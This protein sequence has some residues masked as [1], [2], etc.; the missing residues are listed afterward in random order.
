MPG[1]GSGPR[2]GALGQAA[3]LGEKV[4]ISPSACFILARHQRARYARAAARSLPALGPASAGA[5]GR[6]AGLCEGDRQG[7]E[8]SP[9]RGGLQRPPKRRQVFCL[10]QPVVAGLSCADSRRAQPFS[11]SGCRKLLQN[12]ADPNNI[13]N[14]CLS[15]YSA[16]FHKQHDMVKVLLNKGA[17]PYQRAPCTRG[18]T[19]FDAAKARGGSLVLEAFEKHVANRTASSNSSSASNSTTA[20]LAE[21]LVAI[22]EA[23]HRAAV[24]ALLNSGASPHAEWRNRS[25][26][27]A[28]ADKGHSDVVKLLISRGADPNRPTNASGCFPLHAAVMGGHRDVAFQLITSGADATTLC[29]GRSVADTADAMGHH[30]LATSIRQAIPKRVPSPAPV[31]HNSTDKAIQQATA[32]ATAKTAL[33]HA[34]SLARRKRQPPPTVDALSF[35][36]PATLRTMCAFLTQAGTPKEVAKLHRLRVCARKEH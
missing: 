3:R 12:G 9:L 35:L 27:F 32:L 16:A 7:E 6:G 8:C 1:P 24:A 13:V 10:T 30:E 36:S 5:A 21:E 19:P 4:S 14:G 18:F 23:G 17:N 31:P 28:A 26:L 22:S 11:T 33:K 2:E 34:S 25:A 29:R 15:L 20:A